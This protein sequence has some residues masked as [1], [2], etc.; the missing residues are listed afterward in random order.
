M[1]IRDSDAAAGTV[2]GTGGDYLEHLVDGGSDSL[3]QAWYPEHGGNLLV[4]AGGS[5]SGD[6]IGQRGNNSRMTDAFGVL[7]NAQSSST[8][9]GNWLWRQGTGDVVNAKEATPTA[10]WINFGT[11]VAGH[12]GVLG[13]YGDQPALVGFTGMGTLGGGNLVFETG[14]D[15]GNLAVRGDIC[16]LYTSPSPRD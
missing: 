5:V 7:R 13:E 9:I 8:A 3:Y 2:L 15:A 14:G 16:L 11:Y 12:E 1:C 10:W 6:L 4:R